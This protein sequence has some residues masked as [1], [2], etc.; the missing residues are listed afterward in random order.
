MKRSEFI[1]SLFGL[2]IGLFCPKSKPREYTHEIN[3]PFP[4]TERWWMD[5]KDVWLERS[6]QQSDGNITSYTQITGHK[7][8]P[9]YVIKHHNG[10]ND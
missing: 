9:Y 1:A 3:Y 5:G 10:L 7:Q 8:I 6:I 4:V 2:G